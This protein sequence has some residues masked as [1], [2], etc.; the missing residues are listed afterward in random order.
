MLALLRWAEY[1]F[2]NAGAK[3]WGQGLPN[4]RVCVRCGGGGGRGTKDKRVGQV[5][6]VLDPG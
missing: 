1:G 3:L 5:G 4:G 6:A 2:L